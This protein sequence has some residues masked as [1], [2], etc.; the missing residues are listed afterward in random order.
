[1]RQVYSDLRRPAV[2]FYL[3]GSSSG[4]RPSALSLAA[5]DD[6]LTYDKPEALPFDARHGLGAALLEAGRATMLPSV[7]REEL[8]R[9]SAQRLVAARASE[10]AR[11]P[12]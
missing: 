5:L 8:G 1:M 2:K 12:G 9:P 11:G 3:V 4:N 6:A 7:Y 10:G